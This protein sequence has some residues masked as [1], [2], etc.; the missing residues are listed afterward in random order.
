V[1]LGPVTGQVERGLSRLLEQY[2]DKP[3]LAA[4]IKSYL[5]EVQ[6]LSDAT[7]ETLVSRLIDDA[8]GEQLTVLSRLVGETERFED[9]ER[10]RVLVRARI[11]VN[12][13]DG[14][15]NDVIRV[16]EIIFGLT[17]LIGEPGN[18]YIVVI[19]PEAVSVVPELEWRLLNQARAGGVRLDLY[20]TESAPDD[21]FRW[22]TGPGWGVG[23]W[24]GT[25][26]EH[27][28]P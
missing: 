23:V 12:R 27:T 15:L 24:T 17:P 20:F 28:T 9:D 26:S 13:S 2:K 8:V 21:L 25:I 11:A 5:G 19:V 18:A 6:V 4:L 10:Q 22:G 14:T 7:W 16:A 3:R 1:T